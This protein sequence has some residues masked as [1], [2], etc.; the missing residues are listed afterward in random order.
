MTFEPSTL[1]TMPNEWARV[2]AALDELLALEPDQWPEAIGRIAQGDAALADELQSLLATA[3]EGQRD[4]RVR[5]ADGDEQDPAA[6][7]RAAMPRDLDKVM[8]AMAAHL[9]QGADE[10]ESVPAGDTRPLPARPA[11][12]GMARARGPLP[13]RGGGS[14]RRLLRL[15]L[16]MAIGIGAAALLRW[17]HG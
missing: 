17:S 12:E 9:R 7:R 13:A 5:R 10:G 6:A 14:G 8:L 3:L 1:T 16:A 4:Y 15:T 11:A 2:D